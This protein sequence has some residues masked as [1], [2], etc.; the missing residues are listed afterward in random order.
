MPPTQP[1]PLPAS[2]VRP[3]GPMPGTGSGT[4]PG[5]PDYAPDP[6]GLAFDRFDVEDTAQASLPPGVTGWA[7]AGRRRP[8]EPIT[9]QVKPCCGDVLI[10]EECDCAEFAEQLRLAPVIVMRPFDLRRLAEEHV[11]AAEVDQRER[12]AA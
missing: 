5:G 4:R 3:L 9:V 10:N 7:I 11:T 6:T 1:P 8:A 2:P 12:G